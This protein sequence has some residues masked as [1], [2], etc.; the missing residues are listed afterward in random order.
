MRPLKT[1]EQRKKEAT[2]FLD[3]LANKFRN[4][5]SKKQ[6]GLKAIR[7]IRSI[8]LYGGRRSR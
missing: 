5:D 1:V 7:Y 6:L 8:M 4:G 3:F 2:N